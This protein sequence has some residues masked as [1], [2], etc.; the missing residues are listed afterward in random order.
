MAFC[1]TA[2]ATLSSVPPVVQPC[3]ITLNKG[4]VARLKAEIAGQITKASAQPV[5]FVMLPLPV[6]VR[7]ARL[8]TVTLG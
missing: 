6:I 1:K 3:L 8:H 5:T 2:S 4:V 7:L